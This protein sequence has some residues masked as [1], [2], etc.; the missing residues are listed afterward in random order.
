MWDDASG[1]YWDIP[2]TP[3]RARN[4]PTFTLD[5]MLNRGMDRAKDPTSNIH[6][7]QAKRAVSATQNK[8]LDA[9]YEVPVG[10]A[11]PSRLNVS[12]TP[13]VP[14]RSPILEHV[15][16]IRANEQD[17]KL[18]EICRP[19]GIFA[20][21][22]A[23]MRD[24]RES[25]TQTK[26]KEEGQDDA[27]SIPDIELE[28]SDE[29]WIQPL[30][31]IAKPSPRVLPIEKVAPTLRQSSQ[32]KEYDALPKATGEMWAFQN[33]KSSPPEHRSYK[34]KSA[35]PVVDK[36]DSKVPKHDRNIENVQGE[37]GKSKDSIIF[38]SSDEEGEEYERLVT[39]ANSESEHNGA[40]RKWYK[41]FRR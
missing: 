13:Q 4:R 38:H 35:V 3:S 40:R 29:D 31:T 25:K 18:T 9:I 19:R 39:P 11:Q 32:A 7:C 20:S 12:E 10:V 36:L 24:E 30:R 17:E 23:Q 33:L 1:Q 14:P 21:K 8:K 22:Q 5:D 27:E 2:T 37:V 34:Y 16:K 28:L 6:R 26:R 15:H 41:G